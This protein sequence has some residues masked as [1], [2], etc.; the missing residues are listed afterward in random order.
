MIGAGSLDRLVKLQSATVTNDA[1]SNEPINTWATYA[2][3]YAAM[4]FH[5]TDETE[6]SARRYAERG[7]FFTIRYRADVLPEHR[8]LYQQPDIQ[9]AEVY[10]IVGRPR[11]I[12][13]RQFLKMQVRLV[14]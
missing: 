14:E 7:L 10:E 6:A 1:N 8:I 4:E 12:G 3:V 5:S 11:E 2:T 13:R 9:D